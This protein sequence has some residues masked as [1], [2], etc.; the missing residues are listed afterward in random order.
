MRK[1]PDNGPTFSKPNRRN[2]RRM[3]PLAEQTEV[4][5]EKRRRSLELFHSEGPAAWLD[6]VLKQR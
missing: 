2:Q 1:Y 4:D 3:A 5:A 6:D